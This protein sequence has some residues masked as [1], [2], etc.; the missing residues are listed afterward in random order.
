MADALSV[1][2]LGA[3]GTMGS[4][5]ARNIAR[6]GIELFV[7]NR[8]REKAA[9]LAAAGAGVC[10]TAAEAAASAELIV[11]M[12]SD[13]D[14][15]LAAMEGEHGGLAGARRGSVWVQMATIGE[16]GTTRCIE[17]A[18]QHQ[19]DFI[20]APVLGTKQPAA[21]G[22]LVVMASGAQQL[23]DRVQPVFDAVGRRTM[24][25]GEAGAGTRLKLVTNAWIVS[26][27][28]GVAEAI[29]LA[30]GL[31]LDPELFLQAIDGGPL[32]APYAK[33]KAQAMIDRDFEPT[34]ALKHATKDAKLA[35]DAAARR[36]LDLPVLAAIARR[37]DEAVAAHGDEDLS[38]TYLSSAP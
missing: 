31:E 8:T 16:Q 33:I 21:E 17:L 25:V 26:V 30:Q 37:M 19:I 28:E 36:Q 14:A 13:A 29:A 22:K 34:F 4:G 10:A 11:T 38:A 27:V 7:W 9:P 1:A 24:W 20:D 12:L 5:M 18:N 3:G 2:V 15:L 23:R 35:A 32:E 6:A